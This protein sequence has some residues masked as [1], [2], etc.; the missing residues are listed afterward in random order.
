M[1]FRPECRDKLQGGG[2]LVRLRKE[3]LAM[4]RVELPAI[5]DTPR[6]VANYRGRRQQCSAG[7]TRVMR[8]ENYAIFPPSHFFPKFLPKFLPKDYTSLAFS[9]HMHSIRAQ[10][11]WSLTLPNNRP[12]AESIDAKKLSSVPLVVP[13]WFSLE[14]EVAIRQ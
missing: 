11:L 4:H 13:P 5:R 10:L 12:Y 3:E 2:S 8:G 9:S 1:Q 14:C 6:G 7:G